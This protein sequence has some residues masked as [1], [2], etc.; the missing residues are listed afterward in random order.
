MSVAVITDLTKSYGAELIF[1]GV[2]FRVDP[3]DRIGL[4]GPNGAGKSTLMKL[5]TGQLRPSQGVVRMLGE[6]AYLT[7]E[8]LGTVPLLTS[9]EC[10][11][12]SRVLD[13]LLEVRCTQSGRAPGRHHRIVARVLENMREAIAACRWLS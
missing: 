7:Q 13:L 12:V 10:E 9:P 6:S 2:S 4:V 11:L 3:R 1:S 5:L 8:D